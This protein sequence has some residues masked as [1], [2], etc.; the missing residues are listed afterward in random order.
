VTEHDPEQ[1]I[2]DSA[3]GRRPGRR[4]AAIL[5]SDPAVVA[6]LRLAAVALLVTFLL[7]IFR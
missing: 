6:V 7:W 1:L 4:L 5:P 2:G 3:T